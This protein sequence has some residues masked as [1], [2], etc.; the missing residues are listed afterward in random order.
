MEEV[1]EVQLQPDKYILTALNPR[2]H[3]FGQMLS[4]HKVPFSGQIHNSLRA[5]C[6]AVEAMIYNEQQP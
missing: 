3:F 4:S 6:Y 2:H 5:I 1:A